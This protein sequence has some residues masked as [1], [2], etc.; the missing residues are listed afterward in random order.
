MALRLVQ[1][2]FLVPK[3]EVVPEAKVDEV[4]KKY[5]ATRD[6]LP[7][8]FHSDAAIL[9][10][11]GRKGDVIKITRKSATAGSAIYFRVVI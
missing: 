9:E 7:K 6:K 11:G 8:I 5:G 2:H 3:H 1:D 4:L 10:I